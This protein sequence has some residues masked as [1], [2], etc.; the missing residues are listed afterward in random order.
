MMTE[1]ERYLAT[2]LFQQPDRIPFSPGGGRESTLKAWRTQGLPEDV[3]DCRRYA[4]ELLGI[5]LPP[6][7]EHVS[8]G[9]NFR[10]MPEFEEKV[11]EDLGETWVVQDWKGNVC[12]ISK[13]YGTR[14]LRDAIDFVTRKWIRCPVASRADWDEMQKRYVV[15]TPGRVPDDL[16]DR[17]RRLGDRTTPSGLVFNGPFWQLREWL[18]FEGLCMLFLDDPGLAQ[19]MVDFWERF[20]A[21]LLER[22][23]EHHV[24]DYVLICEDMAYKEKPMIGPDMCR[25]FLLKCWR[26]WGDLSRQ[27]GVPIYEVDS[28]G[29]A[30]QLIPV[31]MEAGINCNS[32]LE[33]AAG[34]DLPAYREQYGTQMAYRGGI[35]KRAMAKGGRVLRDEMD[36]LRPA[37]DA[38]GYIPGCDH[39]IPPDVSWP[40]FVETCRLIAEA[41]GWL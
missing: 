25:E 4:A 6:P 17:G 19:E 38:G 34:N 39:G 13:D 28:D 16:G 12:E 21:Q 5:E 26:A 33:V 20:V 24:P 36:R 18:G 22:I 2:L 14:H 9:V 37:I 3:G 31:W 23:F 10:M 29:H 32:P 7:V 8:V 41:T 27:A 40:N 35:D 11:I 15:D 1:R 30:G